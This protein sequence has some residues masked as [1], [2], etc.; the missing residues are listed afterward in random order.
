MKNFKLIL[1]SF[2][3]LF[4]YTSFAQNNMEDVIYLKNGSI[5]RG[6]VV[7][8]VPNASYKIEIAG[9]S[10][11]AVPLA[12]VEKI[13]KEKK[14]ATPTAVNSDYYSGNNNR[15]MGPDFF[16]RQRDTSTVPIYLRKRR[17]FGSVEF[18]P[19]YNNIGLRFVR[20]YKF[21]Q[22]GFLGLGVGFDA[23]SFDTKF[24]TGK[25]IFN[26]TNVNDGLYIPLYVQYSGE[27]LKK[28]IT[29]YYFVEAG[30]A[31]HP[32]NPF[33]SNPNGNK[34]YGGLTAAAGFG[35][36]MYSRGR[37]S[38]ALNLNA[39]W[40][41]NRWQTTVTSVDAAGNPFSFEKKGRSQRLFG[42]IGLSIGF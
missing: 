28:R 27:I 39:N 4:G 17:F 42:A 8:Q 5:Y 15:M 29:P 2:L 16:N 25:G 18:R 9:G 23:V 30:Y 38:F 31:F 33:V 37:A 24:S 32:T 41:S 35:V 11:I 7:E 3:F 36:K 1:F 34:R 40:R 13:T 21:G 6:L 14:Y 12:D 20:G 19:G 22:F 10:I 26:N